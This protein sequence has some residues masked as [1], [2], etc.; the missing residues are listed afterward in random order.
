MGY[1]KV[2][3]AICIVCGMP[4]FDLNFAGLRRCVLVRV[5]PQRESFADPPTDVTRLLFV[6]A[7][8]QASCSLITSI[9]GAMLGTNGEFERRILSF[10][11]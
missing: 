3:G 6:F 7:D 4:F 10:N 11:Q 9:I 5:A 8:K 2:R 1:G